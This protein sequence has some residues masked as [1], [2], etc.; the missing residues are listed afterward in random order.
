MTYKDHKELL[1]DIA[2]LIDATD[3]DLLR[4]KILK[5]HN[6]VLHIPI[7]IERITQQGLPVLEVFPDL[8]DPLKVRKD[9]SRDDR[10]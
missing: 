6:K 2:S 7:E 8:P 9:N 10:Y 3:N 5:L 4:S 1:V